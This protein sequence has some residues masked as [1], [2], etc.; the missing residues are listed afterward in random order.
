MELRDSAI[1]STDKK[2]IVTS[3]SSPS[4]ER[5]LMLWK[6]RAGVE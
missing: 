5:I 3:W 6:N 4:D 2:E 1:S